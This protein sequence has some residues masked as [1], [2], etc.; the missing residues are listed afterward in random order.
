MVDTAAVLA[1]LDAESAALDEVVAGLPAHRWGLPTPSPGWTIAHQIAHLSWT[2]EVAM[3]A[4][5]DP[6]DF[7]RAL[8]EVAGAGY[9][10]VD[11]AADDLVTEPA[12]MLER[13]R[14][15]RATLGRA[16]AAVP[17]GTRLPW[18]GTAMTAA[19]MATA[20]IMETFAHG[21]D[22]RDA[23]GLPTPPTDRLRHVAH[24]GVRTL[25]H[26]F[27][28]HGLP[29]PDTPVRVELAAP[30]GGTWAYGPE[31]AG[32]RVEGPALD[33]CLLVT[34]RRNRRDLDLRA[35]GRVAD[36]GL[37]V[38]QAFAGPPGAGRAPAPDGGGTAGRRP[39]GGVDPESGG[40]EAP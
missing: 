15:G 31:G 2:D 18:F 27:A 28:A 20:R 40:G 36:R 30:D 11:R 5:T 10:L 25:G 21:T 26:S 12:S 16:L 33:F 4:A 3:R 38:A 7:L 37:D 1:D 9:S 34:Q 19:S 17:A 14:A 29:A 8:A 32:D 24:L 35:T 23:L 13:W 6:E 22:V 39:G